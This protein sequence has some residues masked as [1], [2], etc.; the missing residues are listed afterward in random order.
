MA[1]PKQKIE[2]KKKK[3]DEPKCGE[4]ALERLPILGEVVE[5]NLP[6]LSS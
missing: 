2:E 6:F 5:P 1:E 4:R 3:D